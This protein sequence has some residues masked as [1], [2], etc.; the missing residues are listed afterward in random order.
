M[1]SVLKSG[2]PQGMLLCPPNISVIQMNGGNVWN[3]PKDYEG[4]VLLIIIFSN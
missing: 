4:I 2:H 3:L 1:K